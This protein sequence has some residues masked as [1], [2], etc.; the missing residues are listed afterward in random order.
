[1][2]KGNRTVKPLE[3]YKI[4]SIWYKIKSICSFDLE[5]FESSELKNSDHHYKSQW[6]IMT[7]ATDRLSHC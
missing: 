2:K 6:S 7:T 5:I 3:Y 4:K 1:M